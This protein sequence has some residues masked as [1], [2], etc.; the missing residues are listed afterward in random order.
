MDPNWIDTVLSLSVGLGLA[1][2]AG[3]RVFLPMLLLGL[4]A[5]LGWIPVAPDFQ[6]VAS[7]VALGGFAAATLLEIAAYYVPWL[8][9]ALDAAAA[10]CA[11]AAGILATAAVGVDLPPSVRWG[12]A[13]VAG[14]GTAGAVQALT[15]VARLKSSVFT[16]GLGNPVLAT[17]EWIGALLTALIVI[18]IPAAAIVLAAVLVFAAARVGRRFLRHPPATASGGA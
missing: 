8:D 11:V 16:G 2:A 3:L 5:R 12:A 4:G 13:I 18:V 7:G 9:N 14:G 15:T 10:P 6:W 1:A 17:L